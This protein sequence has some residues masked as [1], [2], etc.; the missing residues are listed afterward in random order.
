MGCK[1][2]Q[3]PDYFQLVASMTRV[4][5]RHSGAAGNLPVG[6]S[7]DSL[8]GLSYSRINYDYHINGQLATAYVRADSIS[9][10]TVTSHDWDALA[11]IKR[12][13]TEYTTESAIT[14]GN[15]ILASRRGAK[16]QSV[17]FNDMLGTT[18]S[19]TS[20]GSRGST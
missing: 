7:D 14:G 16:R 9:A 18:L 11:L 13:N 4:P 6:A 15:P 10:P 19:V 1:K 2:L 17:L 3:L 8:K 5:P 20:R 12:G